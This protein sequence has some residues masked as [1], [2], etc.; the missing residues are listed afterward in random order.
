MQLL[1]PDDPFHLD[2]GS[3]LYIVPFGGCGEF[4]MNLT[5]YLFKGKLYVVDCGI[6]FPDQ[7][8][9]GVDAII[10]DLA[11][12]F[13]K[14]GAPKAY[15]ITHGHED[16]IGALPLVYEKWPA[17]IYAT[18]WTAELIKDRFSK[19]QLLPPNIVNV[20][21]GDTVNTGE[22]TAT[23]LAVNHSIPMTCSV[24]I[25]AGKRRIFHTGDF[26]IDTENPFEP[27]ADLDDFHRRCHP[28]VDAIVVDSTN[29]VTPGSSLPESSVIDPLTDACRG[30]RGTVFITTFASNW[31]RLL[32][33]IGIAQSLER[34]LLVLGAG[35]KRTLATARNLGMFSR[36][37]SIFVD[38]SQLDSI[39]RH[40]LMVLLSGCQGESRSALG[41]LCRDEIKSIKFQP[42]D[43]LIFSS[44]IIPG[45]ERSVYHLSSL[46][47]QKGVEVLTSRSHPGIHVSG[48]AC[49]EDIRKLI[50]AV[51]PRHF[52]PVHGTFTQ[53]MAN[54]DIA[55]SEGIPPEKCLVPEDGCVFSFN[56]RDE[57][58]QKLQFEVS[59]S[60]IDGFSKQPLSRQILKERLK[61]GEMGLAVVSGVFDYTRGDWQQNPMIELRGL[62]APETDY[63]LEEAAESVREAIARGIRHGIV[64]QQSLAERG[65]LA[66]RR[67]LQDY[68]Q[69]KIVVIAHIHL[70]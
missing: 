35:M 4:G 52:I 56:N 69:K 30:V 8:K 62:T 60:F 45:A 27:I 6:M 2:H 34:K 32:V 18:A 61:I 49:Q 39:P 42:S 25:T 19:Y 12:W 46:C 53:L 29:A 33:I 7:T 14:F 11:P 57:L 28:G 21:P 22:L 5:A 13:D 10:P 37:A 9:L 65:R 41:R 66:L 48:H 68:L 17:P 23:Y 51:N 24:L 16:H 1:R 59:W 58:N 64:D 54:R 20:Q 44:R 26:K 67:Y 40:K 15:I 47:A 43:R 36:S 38:E 50:R 70:I 31:W 3:E 63:W 55:V